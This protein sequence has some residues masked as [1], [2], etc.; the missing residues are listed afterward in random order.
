MNPLIPLA[1]IGIASLACTICI[2]RKAI[3]Q[4]KKQDRIQQLENQKPG[5][6]DTDF[7]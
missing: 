6:A 4:A 2:V 1:I 7:Y 5:K 3:R